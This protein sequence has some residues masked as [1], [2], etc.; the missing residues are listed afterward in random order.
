MT[1]DTDSHIFPALVVAD[2]LRA[3]GHHVIWLDSEGSMGECIM[4][5]YDGILFETLAIK[6]VRGNGIRRKLMPP[7]TLYRTI[8]ETQRIIRKHCVGCII[9]FGG[10]VAFPGSLAAKPLGMST[11][12]HKQN[13]VAGLSNR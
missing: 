1:G 12:I 9:G 8:R 3:C 2:S 13:A 10:F 6:G 4:P 5:Q 11:M 7:F